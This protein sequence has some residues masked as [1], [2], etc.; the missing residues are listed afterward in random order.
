MIGTGAS[1]GVQCFVHREP[2]LTM[3]DI[4]F[5][6]GGSHVVRIQDD[7]TPIWEVREEGAKYPP[8][9][10]LDIDLWDALCAAVVDSSG[11][12]PDD[13]LTDTRKVRDRLLALVEKNFE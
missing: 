6:N 4:R 7:G 12:H 8:A 3:V 5:G 2:W 1:R 9:L 13:A 11:G 10:R